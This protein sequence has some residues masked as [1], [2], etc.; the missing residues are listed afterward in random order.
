MVTR[1]HEEEGAR[2]AGLRASPEV[3]TPLTPGISPHDA[4]AEVSDAVPDLPLSG[5]TSPGSSLHGWGP[6]MTLRDDAYVKA[7]SNRE[8][9][10]CSLPVGH[11]SAGD[12]PA[13]SPRHHTGSQ[14]GTGN[15]R[16]PST[17]ACPRSCPSS[18]A[19]ATSAGA[20][21]GVHEDPHLWQWMPH[22]CLCCRVHGPWSPRSP[23]VPWARPC[24]LAVGGCGQHCPCLRRPHAVR[25][26]V[27]SPLLGTSSSSVSQNSSLKSPA[28]GARGGKGLFFER[29]NLEAIQNFRFFSVGLIIYV[30]EEIQPFHLCGFIHDV[31]LDV[32]FL[33]TFF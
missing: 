31:K 32:M 17:L 16:G 15:R 2:D 25:G 9:D 21:P 23:W 6:V 1:G 3:P 27:P 29:L 20:A 28:R 11:P 22:R 26:K 30:F 8:G 7:G 18:P 13:V 4:S 19:G 5:S 14:R 10:T 24:H 33:F 12:S